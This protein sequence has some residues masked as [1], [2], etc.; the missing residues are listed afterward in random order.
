MKLGVAI[1]GKNVP[2]PSESADYFHK[3]GIS[4][5]ELGYNERFTI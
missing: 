4:T 3:H 2:V 5:V 1:C